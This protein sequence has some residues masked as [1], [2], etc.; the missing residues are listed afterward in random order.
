[1]C[2]FFR[3]IDNV[4]QH[5]S[6]VVIATTSVNNSFKSVEYAL[7]KVHFVGSKH[8]ASVLSHLQNYAI[9]KTVTTEY[10]TDRFHVAVRLFSYRSQMAS[11]CCIG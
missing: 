10:L 11:K 2:V 3:E 9:R 1:M 7:T 8:Y 6:V 4:L 5:E